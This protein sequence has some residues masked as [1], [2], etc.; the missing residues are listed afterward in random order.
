MI[1]GKRVLAVVPARSQSSRL[2]GKN[3]KLLLGKPL[4]AWSIEQAL[5]CSEID[6][7]M[8]S[9]DS[10]EIAECSRNFGADVPFL[11]PPSLATDSTS[12]WEV[13]KHVV[14]FY[15]DN[16]DFYDIVVLMQ[17]TSPLRGDAVISEVI[18]KLANGSFESIA[19]VMHA[20]T[21]NFHC[22][23]SDIDILEKVQSSF[24]NHSTADLYRLN[25]AVYAITSGSLKK[26]K[27]NSTPTL[28]YVVM[29]FHQSIDI[30]TAEDFRSAEIMMSCTG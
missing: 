12:S 22:T 16:N 14:N 17:P 18:N 11:R 29:P 10:D 15:T 28:R 5:R 23:I 19:T 1:N 27:R 25:G 30:D 7:V 21:M 13:L 8:V 20:K 24:A 6:R 3:M 26:L 2:P 9:T 4:I